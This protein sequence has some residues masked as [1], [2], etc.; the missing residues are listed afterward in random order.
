MRNRASK[1]IGSNSNR[2]LLAI[3]VFAAAIL[4][5]WWFDAADYYDVGRERR[6]CAAAPAAI[7][8]W[9]LNGRAR[10]PEDRAEL[11]R[12]ISRNSDDINR[13]FGAFC[14]TALHTAARFGRDDLVDLLISRG[15]DPQARD[16]RHRRTPL[17]IA[18]QYGFPNVVTVLLKAG[19][20]V[21]PRDDLGSTPLHEAASGLAGTSDLDGRVEVARRLVARGADLDAR[22]VSGRTPLDVARQPSSNPANAERMSAVLAR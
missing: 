21:D 6:H 13:P 1:T 22:Q 15:A 12:W 17:H 14:Y 16:P 7:D 19:A 8:S 11:E 5:A 20:E 9:S 3:A 4:M 10:R 2:L 18:A